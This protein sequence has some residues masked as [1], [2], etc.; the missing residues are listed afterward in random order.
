MTSNIRR[1]IGTLAPRAA[2]YYGRHHSIKMWSLGDVLQIAI[3]NKGSKARDWSTG[4]YLQPDEVAS[5]IKLLVVHL[6]AVTTKQAM[7]NASA[8]LTRQIKEAG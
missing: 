2:N 1:V 8:E 3:V 4:V 6:E 5:Y 7:L